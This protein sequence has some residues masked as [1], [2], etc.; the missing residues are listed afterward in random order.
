MIKNILSSFALLI[1]ICQSVLSQNKE[2]EKKF[3]KADKLYSKNKSEQAEKV[4]Q[5]LCE[6]YPYSGKVWDKLINMQLNIYQDKKKYDNIF[7]NMTITTKDKNG[8][9]VQNDSLASA[10]KNLLLSVKPSE[11]YL[12]QMINSCRK[13]CCLS[14]ES[15]TASMI[16]RLFKVDADD[17]AKINDDAREQ[18]ADAEKEFKKGNYNTAATYYKKA[19]E[20]DSTFYKAKLYLGDVYYMTKHYGL[21]VD[22]FKNAVNTKPNKLEPRKYLVDAL[23]KLG[24]YENAYHAGI[25]GLMVY[26]DY[27]MMAKVSDAGDAANSKCNF[28]WIIREVFP[29]SMQVKKTGEKEI[30]MSASSADSP[31]KYYT[32]AMEKVKVYSNEDGILSANSITSQKYLELYSWEYMLEKSQAKELE[33]ARKMKE[34]GFLDCYVFISCFHYDFYNQYK[35]FIS[36]NKQRVIKY[37]ELLKGME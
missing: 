15:Y 30:S 21:A 12:T 7:S 31:W 11:I 36:S 16:I 37:F 25:D 17:N 28:H 4:L 34:K 13:A 20:L 1:V 3:I 8:N 32:E 24:E 29:N 14:N 26:P 5:S 18:F 33:F 22:A 6:K 27:S 23:G 2:I 35:D 19:I 9:E 10:L